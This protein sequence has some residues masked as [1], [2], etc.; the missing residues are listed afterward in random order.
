MTPSELSDYQHPS[1][2]SCDLQRSHPGRRLRIASFPGP[3]HDNP[4]IKLFYNALRDD[5]ECG[6][7]PQ[8]LTRE[9]VATYAKDFDALHLHWPEYSWQKFMP[10]Y[11]RALDRMGIRGAIMTAR[12]SHRI[13]SVAGAREFRKA[14]VEA[15]SKGLR[16]IWTFHNT[17]PHNRFRLS[18]SIGLR[19][20][21]MHSDLVIAHDHHAIRK[22]MALYP[23][24]PKPFLMPHGNYDGAFPPPAT[25]ERTF[26]AYGL[27]PA[28]PLF[29]AVG[30]IRPY[31]GFDLVAETAPLLKGRA[32][33]L[34]AGVDRTARFVARHRSTPNLHLYGES[35]SDQAFADLIHAADGIILPYRS[36]TGSGA[37]LATLT[38]GTGVL[39][40]DLPYFKDILQ[41]EPMAGTVL[42]DG[43]PPA[44]VEA[45]DEYLE[46]GKAV[47]GQAAASLAARYKWDYVVDEVR[48]ALRIWRSDLSS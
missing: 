11:L 22:F 48:G 41:L 24:I 12:Q 44:L 37:L 26:E 21:A 17:Q 3:T 1:M 31:K 15:K 5:V 19:A 30:A 42:K 2:S 18:D 33:I 25:R 16:V 23:S 40:S 10:R 39:V 34:I 36:I 13:H 8:V 29:A 38:L 32:Q 27:D 45:I 47:R 4:Y 46:P 43:T 20:M 6:D 7:A 9:W 14:L 35:I 28:L